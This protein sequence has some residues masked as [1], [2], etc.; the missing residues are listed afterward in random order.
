MR[1]R[2]RERRLMGMKAHGRE[3][4]RVFNSLKN[5]NYQKIS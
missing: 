5:G 2:S 1:E 3:N 4:A